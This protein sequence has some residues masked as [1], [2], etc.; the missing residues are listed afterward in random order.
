MVREQRCPFAGCSCHDESLSDAQ[1]EGFRMKTN[2]S[3]RSD[4]RCRL[5]VEKKKKIEVD[6]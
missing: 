5:N 4:G 2:R 6:I 3:E 1:N